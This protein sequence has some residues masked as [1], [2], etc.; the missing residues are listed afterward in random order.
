M[1]PLLRK[2]LG[3]N[4]LLVGLTILLSFFGVV[5]IYSATYFRT[6]EYWEKQAIWW[7]GDLAYFLR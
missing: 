5:A 3:M 2:L 7:Q 4:W 6:S 1:T